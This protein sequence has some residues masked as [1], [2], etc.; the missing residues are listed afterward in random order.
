MSTETNPLAAMLE[1]YDKNNK[2]KFEKTEAKVYDLKNYFTTYIKDGIKSATKQIRILPTADGVSSPFVEQHVH[3]VLV[4]GEWKTFACLKHEKGE[5]C[6]FCEAY[7]ALRSTG[8]ASD[9]ELAKKYNARMMYVVKV[10]DR[11][12]EAEGVKF[13]RFAHDFRKEGILDKIQGVLKAIKKDI[14]DTETG[15][16]LVLTINRNQNNVPVVSAVA[17]LDPSVLSEDAET[18]TAWLSDART[19]EDVYSVRSYDYLK[20]IVTGGVPAW[21]NEKKTFVD[22]NAAG[23]DDEISNLDSE[24]TMGIETVKESIKVA[25]EPTADVPVTEPASTEALDDLPF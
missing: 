21:D 8:N 18:K 6:P 19:W 11:D 3:K 12:N 5:A 4:E 1:Q 20:I 24:I 13:W 25:T 22:K 7:D 23:A 9:K 17:S 10:I 2:P 15:R 14:T 16:D